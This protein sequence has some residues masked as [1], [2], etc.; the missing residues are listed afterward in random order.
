ME[1]DVRAAAARLCEAI[2]AAEKAGYRVQWP[3]SA[4][5]L[6]AIAI[7]ET[8]RVV[9]PPPVPAHGIV[10][11]IVDLPRGARAPSIRSRASAPPSPKE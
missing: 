5:G 4:A 8:G 2:G 6:M 11:E 3:A 1:Q 7:S 9:Q 10:G